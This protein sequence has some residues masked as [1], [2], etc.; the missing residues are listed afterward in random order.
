MATNSLRR[1]LAVHSWS[2]LISTIV[3]LILFVSGLPLIFKSELESL[4]GYGGGTPVAD[5]TQAASAD[6]IVQSAQQAFP[7][8][9]IHYV[10][11]EKDMPGRVLLNIGDTPTSHF[12]TNFNVVM[13]E[14][15]GALVEADPSPLAFF[16]DLHTTLTMGPFGYTLMGLMALLMII[17]LV[18]G[19]VVY[20]PHMRRLEFGEIRQHSPR[21]RWL[22]L[23][24][25]IGMVALGWAVVVGGT[26][27][28]NSWGEYI[29]MGW[30]NSELS[31]IEADYQQ[32]TALPTERVPLDQVLQTA[33]AAVEDKELYYI[34]APGSF[35]STP[36]H[37]SV[38]LRGNDPSTEFLL[39]PVLVDAQSGELTAAPQVPGYISALM[40][41]QPLHFGNYGGMPLKILWVVFDALT[42]ILLGS[43]LYLWWVR[44]HSSR[45]TERKELNV[46][47][48]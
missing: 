28:I 34:A 35:M 9:A 1:W 23:H 24:N 42:I 15:T 47:A 21:L 46:Q 17:A 33:L 14:H 29:L 11:W 31:A 38:Y 36:Y 27:M 44:R 19:A 26:G 25:L 6:A 10:V 16:I 4:L 48:I 8:K 7:D 2:S 12:S 37:Y 39:Q 22:D 32:R 43:G 41:S 5:Q 20:A 18:S 40:L 3:L 45:K 30:R 13:D